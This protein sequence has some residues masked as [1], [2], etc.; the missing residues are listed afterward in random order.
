[1]PMRTVTKDTDTGVFLDY[2]GADT[3]P[4]LRIDLEK[5]VAHY[6]QGRT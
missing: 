6:T 3:D 4:R 1:M 5:P 2:C